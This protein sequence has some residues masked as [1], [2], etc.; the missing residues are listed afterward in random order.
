M[1]Y[2]WGYVRELGAILLPYLG[3]S[4]NAPKRVLGGY[5]GMN[6]T[7]ASKYSGKHVFLP[8]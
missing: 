2:I 8:R 5:R 3:V 1:G 6:G 7:I 4:D